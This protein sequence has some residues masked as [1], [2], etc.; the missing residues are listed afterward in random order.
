[1]EIREKQNLR[2]RYQHIWSIIGSM[3]GGILIDFSHYY[4]GGMIAICLWVLP[5]L[6]G[7]YGDLDTELYLY[8]SGELT[9]LKYYPSIYLKL[10]GSKKIPGKIKRLTHIFLAFPILYT[11]ISICLWFI[12]AKKEYMMILAF[13]FVIIIVLLDIA[14]GIEKIKLRFYYRFRCITK[15]NFKYLILGIIWPPSNRKWPLSRKLGNCMVMTVDIHKRKKYATIK[16]QKTG[17][18]YEKV[19]LAKEVDIHRNTTYKLYEICYVKYIM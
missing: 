19:L 10:Y 15:H 7:M 5:M 6:D 1:M 3:I 9:E 8:S 14:Y 2:W 12:G 17:E 4:L 11:I 16:M 18:V 13:G